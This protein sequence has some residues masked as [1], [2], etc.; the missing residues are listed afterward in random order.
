MSKSTRQIPTISTPLPRGGSNMTIYS[1]RRNGSVES[2]N[3]S[4][5]LE[6]GKKYYRNNE[7]YKCTEI[8]KRG[9]YYDPTNPEVNY[10][11]GV[12]YLVQENDQ[13]AIKYLQGVSKNN[14]DYNGEVMMLLAICHKRQGNL[15]QALEAISKQV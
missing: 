5:L 1:N 3:F 15:P 8:L 10:L 2:R 4:Q 11:L 7:M 12:A 13:E 6:L 14:P 9:L